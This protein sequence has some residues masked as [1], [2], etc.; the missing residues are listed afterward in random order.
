MTGLLAP[1]IKY[2]ADGL[3]WAR[4][5]TQ[6]SWLRKDGTKLRSGHFECG[7]QIGEWTTFDAPYK[8]TTIKTK[9]KN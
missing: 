7:E 8:V 3:L 2:H 5:V 6:H 9:V 4:E 1:S